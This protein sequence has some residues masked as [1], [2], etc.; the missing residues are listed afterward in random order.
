MNLNRSVLILV[1]GHNFEVLGGLC[2]H[3]GVLHL[4]LTITYYAFVL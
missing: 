2:V 1:V 4:C 3:L